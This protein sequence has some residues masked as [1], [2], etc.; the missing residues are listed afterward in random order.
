MAYC[1]NCGTEMPDIA[2]VCP[3]CGT[4]KGAGVN[5]CPV[6]G[7]PTRAGMAAC[8]KCGAALANIDPNVTSIKQ[9]SKIVAILF[10]V[11]LGMFGVHN[12]YL[13]YTAKAVTQ[14]FIT[15]ITCC[16]CAPVSAIWGFIEGILIICGEISTDGKG[17]PLKE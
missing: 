7:E 8:I 17:N 6:C 5:F 15:V 14:L 4:V 1:R 2:K 11:F 13:G 3:R 16:I 10:G 12:F 9:K